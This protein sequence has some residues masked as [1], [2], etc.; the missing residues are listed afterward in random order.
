MFCYGYL[1]GF[2]LIT[3]FFSGDRVRY[4]GSLQRAGIIL[5]GHRS[6]SLPI[7]SICAYHNVNKPFILNE[8]A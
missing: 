6:N 4:I 7:D 3:I 2:V 5:E 1:N 8:I